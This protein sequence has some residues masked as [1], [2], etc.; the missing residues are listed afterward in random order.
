MYGNKDKTLEN[1]NFGGKMKEGF[2]L[3]KL[4]FMMMLLVPVAMFLWPSAIL[5]GPAALVLMA[6]VPLA[7]LLSSAGKFIKL[8]MNFIRF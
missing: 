6:T 8:W 5:S 2:E 3:T 7:I 4:M 1:F